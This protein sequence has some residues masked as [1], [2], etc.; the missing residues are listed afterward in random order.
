[1][2]DADPPRLVE[3]V[4]IAVSF[5]IQSKSVLLTKSFSLGA[6]GY[7]NDTC[8]PVSYVLI[9]YSPVTLE[10]PAAV[11]SLVFHLVVYVVIQSAYTKRTAPICTATA[12]RPCPKRIILLHVNSGY[13]K[14][15]PHLCLF[16]HAS[17]SRVILPNPIAFTMFLHS[18]IQLILLALTHVAYCISLKGQIVELNGISFYLPPKVLGTF[19]FDDNPVVANL[20]DPLYPITF[21]DAAGGNNSLDAIVASYQSLDDVFN[22]GFLKGTVYHY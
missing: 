15:Y 22:I 18:S 4:Q 21:I 14:I 19:G 20:T 7:G 5:T 8:F 2:R 10:K 17:C 11:G 3:L 16:A 1:M 9:N 6:W 13:F 12:L